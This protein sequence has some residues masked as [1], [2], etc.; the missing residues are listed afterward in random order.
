MTTEQRK[1]ETRKKFEKFCNDNNSL[2]FVDKRSKVFNFFY[3][4]I[5]ARDKRAELYEYE[6]EALKRVVREYEADR[7][8]LEEIEKLHDKIDELL[9]KDILE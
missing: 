2:L 3:S 8:H 1:E 9:K 6:V 4:E 7:R 5:E